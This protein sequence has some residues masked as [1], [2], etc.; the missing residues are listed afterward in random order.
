MPDYQILCTSVMT[1]QKSIIIK[2]T[3]LEG[4]MLKVQN[5]LDNEGWEKTTG[6]DGDLVDTYNLAVSGFEVE[7]YH[8]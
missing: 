3:S 7:N 6:G 8:G 4:A 5:S 2:A 1:E